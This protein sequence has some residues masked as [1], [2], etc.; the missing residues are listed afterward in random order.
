MRLP[1]MTASAVVRR[2]VIRLKRTLAIPG[3]PDKFF[4]EV[5]PAGT[6]C[7]TFGE[8]RSSLDRVSIGTRHDTSLGTE[9]AVPGVRCGILRVVVVPDVPWNTVSPGAAAR[10]HAERAP[11]RRRS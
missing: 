8:S 4:G 11:G 6:C 9:Y 10:R 7:P 2:T 5:R 1:V 3:W